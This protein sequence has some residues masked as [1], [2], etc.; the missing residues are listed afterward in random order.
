VPL[1]PASHGCSRVH[2]RDADL[3]FDIV[4]NGM[5]VVTWL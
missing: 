1:F 2:N 5:T 3:L 4:P